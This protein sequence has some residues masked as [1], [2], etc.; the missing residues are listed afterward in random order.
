MQTTWCVSEIPYLKL[1]NVSNKDDSSICKRFL[2]S[3][4][5]KRNKERQH[6]L[7]ELSISENLLSRQLSTTDFYIFKK[8]I[9]SHNNKSLQKLL[10]TRQKKLSS[11]TRGCSLPLFTANELLLNLNNM[12]YTRKNPS[13][14]KQVYTF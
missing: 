7:K 1:P 5:N 2:R 10:F 14:L 12:N 9:T 3:A 6:V 4:I 8:S 13:Y 11:L